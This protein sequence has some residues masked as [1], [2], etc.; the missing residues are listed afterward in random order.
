MADT[1]KIRAKLLGSDTDLRILINHP[2]ETGNRKDD[3]GV[4]VPAH[5]IQ[6]LRVTHNDRLL[7][8]AAYGV[9]VAQ[10]PYLRLRLLGAKVGDRISVAWQDNRG[11][12]DSAEAQV[13]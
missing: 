12:K 8:D 11:G 3:K 6:S 1:I 10:N 4:L 5:F 2:M 9:G 7:V 13:Q